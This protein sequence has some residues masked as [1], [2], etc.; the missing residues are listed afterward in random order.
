MHT[1]KLEEFLPELQS[2]VSYFRLPYDTQNIRNT[3]DEMEL[4]SMVSKEFRVIFRQQEVMKT[5]LQYDGT[6]AVEGQ[7]GRKRS[8]MALRK[9]ANWIP[10]IQR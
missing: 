4:F 1:V 3:A 5:F 6:E 7:W 9:N 8:S 2:L 10:Y